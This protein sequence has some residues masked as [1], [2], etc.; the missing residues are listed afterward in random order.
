[1]NDDIT[2]DSDSS[3]FSTSVSHSKSTSIDKKLPITIKPVTITPSVN[4]NQNKY[5]NHNQAK[6]DAWRNSFFSTF[7][8]SFLRTNKSQSNALFVQ[9]SR[10]FNQ[11]SKFDHRNFLVQNHHKQSQLNFKRV[12]FSGH[13]GPVWSLDFD[14]EL[15]ISASYDKT[16][17]LWTMLN[18]NCRATLRGHGGILYYTQH[19]TYYS[20]YIC[21]C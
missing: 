8:S 17:K 11:Y 21:V 20:T 13:G 5:L 6:L 12:S 7:S 9:H 2:Y 3:S 10:P 1:M 14:Q 16:I 15:L 4:H 19:C 18:G